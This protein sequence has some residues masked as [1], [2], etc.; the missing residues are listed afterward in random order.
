MFARS[1]S[2]PSIG[3]DFGDDWP[4]WTLEQLVER[5]LLQQLVACAQLAVYTGDLGVEELEPFFHTFG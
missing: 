5:R 1:T 2:Y 3:G 4:V